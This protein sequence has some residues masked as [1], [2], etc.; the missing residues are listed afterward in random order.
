MNFRRTFLEVLLSQFFFSEQSSQM[1]Q[2]SKQQSH[3]KLL[4]ILALGLCLFFN[5]AV[6]ASFFSSADSFVNPNINP[7]DPTDYGV[8]VTTPIHHHLQG[9]SYFKD[10]YDKMM[11]GCYSKYSRRECDSCEES[12]IEMNLEQ[13]SSQHNYTE[14]GFK[15][16]RV[17]AEPWKALRD[18]YDANKH[19][20]KLESWPRGNTY[21]NHWDAP[22][23][24]ISFEDRS[25]RGGIDVKEK[26]WEGVKPIIEA[27]V[28]R[29]IKPTSLY[30]IRSYKRGSILATR[31]STKTKKSKKSNKE[32]KKQRNVGG[33]KRALFL[34]L[35]LL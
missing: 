35:L 1:K 33:K 19:K 18:F 15:K 10:V 17:P 6:E 22:S 29:P 14:M 26:I 5:S 12:R 9:K 25:L 21:V 7:D 24:M 3:G 30:G 34:L 8:D 4:S 13:T 27:W 28:G 2:Q 20:E 11:S 23:Y 16:L 32:S 31:K